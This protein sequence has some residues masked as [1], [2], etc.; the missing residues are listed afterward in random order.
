M[1]CKTC[2]HVCP[3]RAYT[4]SLNRPLEKKKVA[5]CEAQCPIRNDVEGF[6]TL[7]GQ[8]KYLEAYRL[9]SET[10]PFPGT[11]GRVCHHPCEQ[12]CN[13]Q[14]FDGEV[15]IQSL[16][17]FVADYAMQRDYKPTRP[18]AA[19]NQVVAVIGAGPAGLSSAYHLARLGYKVTLFEASKKPG[20]LLRYGIPEY[21]LPKRILDWEIRNISSMDVKIRTSQRLGK[22]LKLSDL[23]EFDALFIS[24]GLQENIPLKIPGE[25]AKGVFSALGLLR[26]VNEGRKV[27]LG[28][29]VAVIGGG[30]SALDAAR[31]ALRLGCEPM[32]LYR[33]SIEEMPGFESERHELIQEGIQ[34]LPFVMPSRIIVEKGKIRQIECLKTRPGEMGTDGRRV[35]VPVE[36][37]EFLLDI[38]NVIVASGEAPDFSAFPPS[39]KARDGRWFVD[40]SGATSRR[41]IFAGGDLV[42]EARTVSDAIASGMRGA[43]AIHRFLRKEGEDRKGLETGVVKFEELNSDYFYPA[44]RIVPCHVDPAQAISSFDEVVLGLPKELAVQESQRCFGC[45]APPTYKPA[46]CRGC[47]NCAER[48][49]TSAITIEPQKQP[50]VVGVDPNQC[51]PDEI[52]RICRQAKVHPKQIICYCTNTTAG[53]IAAAII[54]GARTPEEVSL[55]TGAR[56]GCTVLCVQSIIRLLEASGQPVLP[57]ETHQCYGKTFTVWDADARLKQRYEAQGYHFDEDIRLIEKVFEHE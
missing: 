26:A 1:G 49:P 40:P 36:D 8:K 32:V 51:D 25:G 48:C 7:I 35:P 30:N 14:N 31:C 43:M 12:S 37:S 55:M 54:K 29:R 33:R 6:I 17:R 57:K 50:F 24:I 5:P 19:Q 42:A 10:N 41:G 4:P 20:G 47:V 2:T 18:K 53:E 15:S 52:L 13:R 23:K 9:L 45:A 34:V 46:D 28:R 22:N 27:G 11:T 16:E 56:T 44:P 3:T 39:L 38:D 21:R